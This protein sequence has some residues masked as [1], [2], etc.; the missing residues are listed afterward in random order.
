[1]V[2]VTLA[3]QERPP[4]DELSKDARER[5]DVD[6]WPVLLAPKQQLWGAI[7]ACKNLVSERPVWSAKDAGKAEICLYNIDRALVNAWFGRPEK[8]A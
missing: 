8:R 6:T 4:E 7:P 1:L 3:Q 5:P 2:H